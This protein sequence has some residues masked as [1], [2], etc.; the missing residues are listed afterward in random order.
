MLIY[1]G[2]SLPFW[3][4]AKLNFRP[5]IGPLTGV[6]FLLF[7]IFTLHAV[8]GPEELVIGDVYS[9]YTWF[10]K[11]GPIVVT[12][13]T[14]TRG[15]FMAMRLMVPLTI[16]LLVIAT[17]DPTYLA[18]GMRKLGTPIELVFMTLAA[19]RFIPLMTEQLFNILDAQTI[20]GVGESRVQKTKLLLLPLFITSLRRTR[21]MGL[22]CEAKAFGKRTWN[23]FYEELIL[24]TT[25]KIVLVTLAVLTILSIFVRFGL[26]LGTVP[27]GWIK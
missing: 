10:V 24:T 11:L 6:A 15:L 19:L 9:A 20:R 16:G 4:T 25:D 18:K 21:I 26:G 5:M 17:T 7:V 3:L 27:I 2:L 23:N 12:S 22:A 14:V 13:H 1:I 8:R